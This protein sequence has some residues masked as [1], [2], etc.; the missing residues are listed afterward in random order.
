MHLNHVVQIVTFYNVIRNSWPKFGEI[1][2]V[3]KIIYFEVSLIIS[4]RPKS[5][6]GLFSYGLITRNLHKCEP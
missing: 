4:F 3:V 6:V 1:M 5:R 2:Q